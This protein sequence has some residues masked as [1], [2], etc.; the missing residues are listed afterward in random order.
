M[1]PV[2]P[3]VSETLTTILTPVVSISFHVRCTMRPIGLVFLLRP[4]GFMAVLLIS[5]PSRPGTHKWACQSP[6]AKSSDRLV[7]W[8]GSLGVAPSSHTLLSA[9]TMLRTYGGAI[10]I[11]AT[12]RSLLSS[13]CQLVNV[14]VFSGS[15]AI[16]GGNRRCSYMG[17][18]KGEA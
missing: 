12:D 7:R 2:L 8:R 13:N 10:L 15:A 1:P 11:Y 17:E 5:K 16:C 18:S 3:T 4:G 9:L 14:P 6:I